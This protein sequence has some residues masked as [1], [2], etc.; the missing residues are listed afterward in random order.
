M[1]SGRTPRARRSEN[2]GYV[3]WPL[4]NKQGASYDRKAFQV[5]AIEKGRTTKAWVLEKFG[6]PRSRTI[7]PGTETWHYSYTEIDR[8][9]PGFSFGR[10]AKPPRTDLLMIWF[11]GDVVTNYQVTVGTQ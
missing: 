10:P 2:A 9:Q 6:E 3:A 1:A 4:V 8:L 5:H 11:S 7:A